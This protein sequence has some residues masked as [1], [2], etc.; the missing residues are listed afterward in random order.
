MTWKRKWQPSLVLLPGKSHGWRSLVGYSPC[1]CKESDTSE[2]LHFTHSI[3]FILYHW[4]RKWQ[5]TPM[6]LP[7]E[8]Y[9]WRSMAGHGPWDRRESGTTSVT[10][11]AHMHYDWVLLEFITFRLIYAQLSSGAQSA[12]TL[13]DPMDCRPGFPVHHQLPE[14]AQTHVLWVNDAI[15]PSHPPSSPSPPTFNL[16]QHQGIF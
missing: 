11:H 5:P 4:R 7:G 2:Q 12:P 15:Q 16:S 10:K 3:H 8:S 14:L 9:G 13:C 6:F 1:G